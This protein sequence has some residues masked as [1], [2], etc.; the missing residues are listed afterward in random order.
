MKITWKK[1]Q[2][3]PE[4]AAVKQLYHSAFPKEEQMPWWLLRLISLRR[5]MGI[6]AYYSDGAF[7]GM[8]VTVGTEQYLFVL[9]F[10]VADDCRGQGYGSE[11][12]TVLQRENPNRPIVLN[13]EPLDE[14]AEN[15]AQ[16]VMRMRFYE[17]NG[18][19]DTG[20]NID[21]VGGTFRVLSN[22]PLNVDGYRR[23]F[24]RLSYGLWRPY[25]RTVAEDDK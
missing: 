20:Y 14:S 21:E 1:W 4:K 16:R 19:Y 24:S 7:C 5:D 25:I 6:T 15:A 17:R 11:I 10:A 18:F 9:F 12:L 13:V 8:T 3:V 23:V 22:R 2:D